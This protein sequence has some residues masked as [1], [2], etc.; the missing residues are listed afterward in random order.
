MSIN[1]EETMPLETDN[2][3]YL[4]YYFE[5]ELPLFQKL[6]TIIKKG[7][8]FQKQALLSKL[9]LFQTSNL[10]KSLMQYILNDIETWDKETITLFPKYLHPLLAKPKDILIKSIDNELFNLILKKI[11]AI[12]SSTEEYISR[13]YMKYIEQTILFYNETKFIFPYIINEDIYDDI[14]CLGKFG[15]SILNKQLSCCL[16]CA[17]IR[18]INNINDENVQKL[19]NRVC[20]LFSYCDKEIETQ[21]S[22]ELE[23]LFP[24]FKEKLIENS[25]ITKAV[26]SYLNRDSDFVLQT[27][28]IVS[29][30]K[31][32]QWINY[33]DLVG[34]L[35]DKIK[36]IFGD[37]VNYEQENKNKIFLE[38]IKNLEINYKII[39]INIIK[40][41]FENDFIA[42]FIINNKTQ[43]IILQNFDKIYFIFE[44]M[45]NDILNNNNEEEENEEH[46]I[47]TLIVESKINYDD[48]FYEIYNHYLNINYTNNYC[49]YRKKTFTEEEKILRKILYINLMKV[50]PFLSDFK[51]NKCIYDKILYLFNND[52]IIFALQCFSEKFGYNEKNEEKKENNILY[53]LM[54]FCL[55]KNS[56]SCKPNS[57]SYIK[58]SNMK[59]LS[60]TKKETLNH[61]SYYFKL[62]YNI[63]NNIFH[64]FNETPGSFNNNI[65]L[66]LCDFFQKIIKKI[67]KYLTPQMKDLSNSIINSLFLGN[68]N[69]FKVKSID[70]IFEDIYLNYLIKLVDKTNLGY[71]VRSELIKIFPYLILY[72]KN[73][74]TYFKYI[75][76]H[77]IQS[78]T[79]FNRRYAV[80]YLEKCFQIFSFKMFNKIGLTDYLI[81][82][83]NDENTSKGI[84]QYN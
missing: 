4:K 82:M 10:F 26:N 63:L 75:Q 49:T 53:D 65:H 73:R 2:D 61:E 14:I 5:E 24:I 8:P 76:E 84:H 9:N 30:I 1:Y 25:E 12:I 20:Y 37:E 3:E 29:I 79:Y 19:F 64:A 62:F 66:L 17:I 54:Y 13:E 11:I 27:T 16:C 36:E 71:H 38:L 6:N 56:S 23:F 15:E 77:I 35:I 50:M 32:L 74:V 45:L 83:I 67:Y 70:K 18:L 33:G 69:K 40:K 21:L 31:N 80:V 57:C 39:D 78:K 81:T 47:N 51:K 43:E 52:N 28:T 68:G 44:H 22:R 60:P 46:K 58:I 7:E 34:K 72:G 42:K 48:L 55:K 59:S 41:L